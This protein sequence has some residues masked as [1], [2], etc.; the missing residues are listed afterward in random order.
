[1]RRQPVVLL[2]DPL[3]IRC[4]Q[5]GQTLVLEVEVKQRLAGYA[6]RQPVGQTLPEEGG[7]AA[8]PH[9][10]DGHGFARHRWQARIARRKRRYR[11]RQRIRDQLP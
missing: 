7:F 4:L 6:S 11:S 5:I 2:H 1:M 10:N 8:A 9:A 3:Q